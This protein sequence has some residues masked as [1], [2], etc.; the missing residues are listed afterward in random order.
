MANSKRR[1][2]QCKKYF[3]QSSGMVRGALFFCS[4]SH[5]IDYAGANVKRLAAKG[6]EKQVKEFRAETRKRKE[7]LRTKPWY[8]K[9][10]QKWFNKRIRLRDNGKPC[11]SCGRPYRLTFGGAF[12]CGHYRSV[13][14]CPELRFEEL[15]AAA[16]CVRCNRDLSG[17]VAEYRKG[18]IDRIGQDK[19]DWIEGHHHTKKYT[20]DDLKKIIEENKAICK[21]LEAKI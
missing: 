5:L 6:K 17:N 10:A 3:E 21:E 7:A 1:C 8:I 11:I 13:G 18:L 20:I 19:V 12:D 2:A 15:N 16:Q 4:Q 9:E 14:S